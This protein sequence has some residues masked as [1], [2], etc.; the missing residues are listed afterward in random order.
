MTDRVAGITVKRCGD[1]RIETIK[2]T[3]PLRPK[4]IHV[5]M[6]KKEK[7]ISCGCRNARDDT[8]EARVCKSVRVPFHVLKTSVSITK[9]ERLCLSDT[10]RGISSSIKEWTTVDPRNSICHP[11]LQW[12]VGIEANGAKLVGNPHEVRGKQ[13]GG[14][15]VE[16]PIWKRYTGIDCLQ[17]AF[18]IEQIGTVPRQK[19]RC[20]M[21]LR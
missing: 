6:K 1:S 17:F 9:G 2:S 19:S 18:E 16:A 7:W 8:P 12:I 21:G 5:S 4:P 15:L 10:A 20:T 14:R 3:L 13:I 11:E